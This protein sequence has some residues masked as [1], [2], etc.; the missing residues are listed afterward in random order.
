MIP[1]LENHLFILFFGHFLTL[2]FPS[3]LS[4]YLSSFGSFLSL[5]LTPFN[6]PFDQES[7]LTSRERSGV[8]GELSTPDH[9]RLTNVKRCYICHEC[10]G[11]Y[12]SRETNY[13]DTDLSLMPYH[14]CQ[15]SITISLL[16]SCSLTLNALPDGDGDK[17]P[18]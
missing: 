8:K 11:R 3:S 6:S 14:C 10:D 18:E 1:F 2:Y 9:I 5:F 16:A 15:Q 12:D 17:E 13:N 4:H 7:W